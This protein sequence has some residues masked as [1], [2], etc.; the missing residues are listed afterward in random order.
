M[1]KGNGKPKMAK[2]KGKPKQKPMM[3]PKGKKC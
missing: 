1:A 3:K 2:S